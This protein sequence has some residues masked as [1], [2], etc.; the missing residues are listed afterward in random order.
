MGDRVSHDVHDGLAAK[1][2]SAD[3][4]PDSASGGAVG[5][6]AERGFDPVV[7]MAVCWACLLYTSPSPRD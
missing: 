7:G 1:V 4:H 5:N 6:G 3:N 2:R